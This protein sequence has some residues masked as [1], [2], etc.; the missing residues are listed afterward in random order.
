MLKGCHKLTKLLEKMRDRVNL[1][2]LTLQMRIQLERDASG[3]I[4]KLTNQ[5]LGIS[6][7]QEVIKK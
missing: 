1:Q 2:H 7:N 4:E 6:P 5:L 3:N